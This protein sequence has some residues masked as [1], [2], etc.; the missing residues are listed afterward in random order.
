MTAPM[1]TRFRD[2]RPFMRSTAL[3]VLVAFFMLILEPTV[4]AA[5]TAS[6]K[7]NAPK[8]PAVTAPSAPSDD[9]RFSQTLQ[10]IEA[11]LQRLQ[12]KLNKQQAHAAERSELLQLQH[13][14][15]QLDLI[16]RQSF[17]DIEQQLIKHR[18]PSEILARHQDMVDHYQAEYDALTAELDAI[19]NAGNDADRLSRVQTALEHLKAKPNKKRQQPFDPNQLPNQIPDGKIR[20]PK[21]TKEEL[22]K[23]IQTQAAPVQV[24]ALELS[25]GM[26]AQTTTQTTVPQAADLAATEDVQITDDIKTL[27]KTLNNEPVAIYN[28]VRNNIE[29]LPTYGSIQGS[30]LTLR[31]RRGNAFDTASLLISLLRASNIPARYAYGTIKVPADKVMNWVGNVDTPEAA[32][33]LLGSGDIPV[34]GI[35]AGGKITSFKLEHVWVEAFV[36]YIP[37]RGAV[38]KQGDSWVALDAAF[39]QY[40]YTEGMDI[41][42]IVP[43]D[44]PRL[45][46]QI[47]INATLNEAEGWVQNLNGTALKTE[48]TDYQVRVQ[49][50]IDNRKPNATVGDVLGDKKVI[51]QKF[52]VLM[53]GMPYTTIARL[54]AF[55]ALPNKLRHYF[56]LKLYSTGLDRATDSPSLSYSISLPKISSQRIGLTFIPSSDTDAQTLQSYRD[57]QDLGELPLYLIHVKPVL[58]LDGQTLATGESLVM[59]SDHYWESSFSSPNNAN[60]YSHTYEVTAGDEVVFSVNGNGLTPS[61]IQARASAV[62]ADTASENLHQAALHYWVV[63]DELDKSI[64]KAQGVVSQRKP[65]TGLFSSPLAVTYL[66]GLPR[67]GSYHSRNM[68]ISRLASAVSG[69]DPLSRAHYISTT[70]ALGSALEGIIFEKLFGGKPGA[71]NSTMQLLAAA[72]EAKIPLYIISQDN[73]ATVLPRLQQSQEVLSDI[74]NAVNAGKIVITPAS[75]L[76]RFGWT[77]TGYL[78]QDPATGEGAYLISGGKNGGELVDCRKQNEPL[79]SSIRDFILSMTLLAE[80]ALLVIALSPEIE[81]GLAAEALLETV[82][83]S[84]DIKALMATLGLSS[85]V[86][87]TGANASPNSYAYPPGA[88]ICGGG[89]CGTPAMYRGATDECPWPNMDCIRPNDINSG[90][91]S[92]ENGI[93]YIDPD[94]EKMPAQ[95]GISTVDR[96]RD[97]PKVTGGWYEYP[98]EDPT[99]IPIGLCVVSNGKGHWAWQPKEKMSTDS[100]KELLRLTHP[101]FNKVN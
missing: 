58:Q 57:Q 77:G 75:P 13:S 78:I 4:A 42:T 24:A 60:S 5:K 54:D 12:E 18:L 35:I 7:A 66:F 62:D 33:N 65:S 90:A 56:N 10:Q 27:A 39:K 11:Q 73:L 37:S 74:A 83:A 28:W 47:Q 8:A 44:A 25:A 67:K 51:E 31:T 26:L 53:S 88:K 63:N 84:I 59:G 55:A 36:D 49:A 3:T 52:P 20:A 32:Q 81:L 48:L 68:D 96:P 93:E 17:A 19:N 23:L 45:L 41:K 16:E 87:S 1:L 30:D 80:L 61:V 9:Q 71:G 92:I 69:T 82:G 89:D 43:L 99:G 79:T 95:Y 70:G 34:V 76:T 2:T 22:E 29:F 50:Y 21:E 86:L 14:L 91:K 100:F 94:P 72:N 101:K 97:N 40:Q 15:K 46:D 98:E 38:N 64:A 85:L 6:P